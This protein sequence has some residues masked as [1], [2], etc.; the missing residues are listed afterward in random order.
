MTDDAPTP[1][2]PHPPHPP[3]V[4]AYRAPGQDVRPVRSGVVA[5]VAV[6]VGGTLFGAVP[7]SLIVAYGSQ[8]EWL[9]LAAPALLLVF[10]AAAVV[11]HWRRIGRS[12]VLGIWLGI[13]LALLGQGLCWGII[14]MS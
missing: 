7:A 3:D 13:G 11:L 12:V 9:V 8:W 5:T 4:L 14:A 6:G 2:E 1:E 10:I